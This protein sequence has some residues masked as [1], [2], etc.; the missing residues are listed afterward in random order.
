MDSDRHNRRDMDFRCLHS[1]E[2]GFAS[3]LL[4]PSLHELGGWVSHLEKE[5]SSIDTLRGV[6]QF[7]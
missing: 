6:R 3:P 2:V 1:V 5:A 4:I 7:S